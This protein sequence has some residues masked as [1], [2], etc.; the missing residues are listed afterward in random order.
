M[1]RRFAIKQILIMAGGLALLPSCLRES[2]KSSILLKNIDVDFDQEMLLAEVV[3]T[4]IP[5]TTTPGGKELKLH[6]FVLKMLDDCYEKEDQKAFF[7]GLE[8]LQDYTKK[9]FD[10][11]FSKLVAPERE[12][13][14]LHLENEDSATG[15]GKAFYNILKSRAIGGYLNSQYVMTNLL[16]WELVP[17]RYNGFYPV[18]TA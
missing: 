9:Q 18:K 10:K 13:V 12:Q 6:L 2:G 4:I 5:T 7:N 8:Y 14:L 3:E 16:K 11:P 15:D 17:S 1:E